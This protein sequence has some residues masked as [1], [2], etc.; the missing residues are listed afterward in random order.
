LHN[1]T[2]DPKEQT[3]ELKALKPATRFFLP[4]LDTIVTYLISSISLTIKWDAFT[5][6]EDTRETREKIELHFPIEEEEL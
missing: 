3:S 6:E 2:I 4:F 5:V 1:I